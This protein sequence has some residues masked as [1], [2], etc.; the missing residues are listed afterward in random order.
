MSAPT[1][2]YVTYLDADKR[3][4][5][6]EDATYKRVTINEVIH[7]D[8]TESLL[9]E[10]TALLTTGMKG[11]DER[12]TLT[13]D[14]VVTLMMDGWRDGKWSTRDEV[15]ALSSCRHDLMAVEARK[16]ATQ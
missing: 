9:D 13:R 15:E 8:G 14:E 11:G 1:R 7:E 4:A 10:W 5:R 2:R 3:P 12:T 16:E 6:R